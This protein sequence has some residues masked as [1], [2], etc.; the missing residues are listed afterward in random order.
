MNDGT[1]KLLDTIVNS[2]FESDLDTID[3]LANNEEIP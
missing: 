1:I 3:K 2:L